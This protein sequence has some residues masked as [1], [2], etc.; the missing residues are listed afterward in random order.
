MP[1]R[2]CCPRQM[3]RKSIRKRSSSPIAQV[4][5]PS[6]LRGRVAPAPAGCG[7]SRSPTPTPASDSPTPRM[8]ARTVRRSRPAAAWTAIPSST[9][10]PPRPHAFLV[11]Q[12]RF[13]RARM[14]ASGS[15]DVN[16]E[17]I[18]SS[19]RALPQ[20]P[21]AAT[22]P[23][24][25]SNTPTRRQDVTAAWA[26]FRPS[27]CVRCLERASGLPSDGEV[28]PYLSPFFDPGACAD[29]HAGGVVRRCLND[30]GLVRR[31]LSRR[32]RGGSGGAPRRPAGG[33]L[34]RRAAGTARCCLPWSTQG[35][36]GSFWTLSCSPR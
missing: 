18:P 31:A 29:G 21:S 9:G 28:R 13:V 34:R 1:R 36:A 11:H 3:W 6:I 15:H 4:S 10:L 19:T 16:H 8:S 2:R 33:V 35:P 17:G 7:A 12:Q 32:A 26:I 24:N 30:A 20:P 25:S 23:T 27:W 14:L 5:G 22:A